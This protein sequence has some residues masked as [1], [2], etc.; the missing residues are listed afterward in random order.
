MLDYVGH[1]WWSTWDKGGGV[2]GTQEVGGTGVG[3]GWEAEEEVQGNWKDIR[4]WSKEPLFRRGRKCEAGEGCLLLV[5]A[6]V[7]PMTSQVASQPTNHTSQPDGPSSPP[8]I[9]T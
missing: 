8:A 4:R 5:L 7:P 2:R 6:G 3:G 1:R 9:W